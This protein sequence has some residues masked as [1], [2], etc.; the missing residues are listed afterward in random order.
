MAKEIKKE[1][2][3]EKV[4]VKKVVDDQPKLRRCRPIGID[5]DS[6]LG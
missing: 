2:V 6:H 4:V 3:V 1:V 5:K